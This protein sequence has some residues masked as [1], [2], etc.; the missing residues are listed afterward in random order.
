MDQPPKR[1]SLAKKL[2]LGT[3][4]LVVLAH[5]ASAVASHVTGSMDY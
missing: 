3:L 5:V 4:A 2:A 1:M